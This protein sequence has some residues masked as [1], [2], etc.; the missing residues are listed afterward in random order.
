[1]KKIV[2]LK[3]V[4]EG[5]QIKKEFFMKTRLVFCVF[6]SCM[7]F[8][9]HISAITIKEYVGN[10][11][12]QP[13]TDAAYPCVIYDANEFDG[14]GAAFFYK[15][16]CEG[17][18]NTVALSYSNDGISWH[19]TGETNLSNAHHPFV[20]YDENN[21]GGGAFPYKMWYWTGTNLTLI[22]AMQYAESA[23]GLTWT[24]PIPLTQ[25]PVFQLVDGVA[26]SYF[27]HIYGPGFVIY[28]SLA[29]PI[30]GDPYSY[31]YVMLYDTSSEGQPPTSSNQQTALAYSM[32]GVHWTRYGT[33]P[34]MIPSG[35][36]EWDG[37]YI[38][39]PSVIQL[40][41][42]YHMFYSGS[43][44][45]PAITTA[46]Y[47]AHGIGYATSADGITWTKDPSPVFIYSDGVAW[48]SSRTYNPFALIAPVTGCTGSPVD[49]LQMWFTGSTGRPT[50]ERKAIGYAYSVEDFCCSSRCQGI[51]Q[52]IMNNVLPKLCE[53]DGS[54]SRDILQIP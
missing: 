16:W 50:D 28:N 24:A 39:R 33:V 34:I 26:G 23:D 30:P 29:V 27:F 37:K 49:I 38:Y 1:M 12:Y 18:G 14:N 52:L 4:K 40:N 2:I 25:D 43:D 13:S 48:R 54:R 44:Y 32:D 51:K 22:D 53:L 36:K 47:Y 11:I 8:V 5:Y 15:M 21:F 42:V 3:R 6:L 45:S 20:V 10:P 35:G 41:G 31:P 7:L 17:P 46:A 9:I 19:M